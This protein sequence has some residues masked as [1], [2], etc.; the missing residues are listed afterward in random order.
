MKKILFSILLVL[1]L[2]AVATPTAAARKVRVGTRFNLV[3]GTP[4]TFTAGAPFHIAHGWIEASDDDA[5]GIFEFQLEVD[6]VLQTAD[7]VERSA[8]SG[9]PDV[10]TRVWVF[11]FPNGMTGT[12]T[13]T[14]H[15]LGPCQ[16]LVDHGLFTGPCSTPNEKVEA[17]S[18]TLTVTFG[19]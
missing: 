10:L 7:F 3:A 16:T 2:L 4:T 12:H 17:F 6:N 19:P 15:W 13:F 8:E 1:S 18:R 5:I 14:G 9:N 11:N